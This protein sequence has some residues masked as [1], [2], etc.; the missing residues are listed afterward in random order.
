MTLLCLSRYSSIYGIYLF[1]RDSTKYIGLH[2]NPPSFVRSLRHFGIAE[3]L[4]PES[5][6]F[7]GHLE[8]KKASIF[9]NQ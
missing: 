8:I 3:N 6:S 4:R 1:F 9:G 7:D 5:Q 2:V